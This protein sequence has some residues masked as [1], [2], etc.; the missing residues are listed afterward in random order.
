[1]NRQYVNPVPQ[2]DYS[3]RFTLD[4]KTEYV[5]FF[6]RN[7]GYQ[8]GV[9]NSFTLD[10]VEIGYQGYALTLKESKDYWPFGLELQQSEATAI[11]RGREYTYRQ[12]QG[13][14]HT[15]ELGLNIHEWR[16]RVSDPTIGR[17]WQVDPLAEE[18]MDWAPYVFSGN[19]LIDARELE[20]L[21]PVSIHSRSFIPFRTLGMFGEGG[22]FSGDN[23]GFGD[24]GRSRISGRTD[25]NLSGSGIE[26]L[27][28]KATGADTFDSDGNFIVHSDA[29][30]EL[31]EFGEQ[32]FADGTVAATNLRFHVSGNNDAIDGSPD[33]D[34]KGAFGIGVV[35]NKDG[36]SIATISGRISGDK[37]PVSETFITDQNGTRIFLGVSGA[38]GTPFT[39][40]PGNNNRTMSSFSI[41]VKFDTNGNAT[42]VNYN[43]TSFSIEDWNKRFTNLN[44]ASNISTND[45]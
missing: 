5:D 32:N 7:N 19:R 3:T 13:Q 15:K 39:S 38:D 30:F 23:R 37:F 10:N 11:T 42:G 4:P 16:Y 18:Y 14:E 41:N 35:D 27:G 29:N 20:G 22:S 45:N 12:F 17:F 34:L 43:G 1:M 26:L 33:I 40:L 36:S 8:D 28:R 9:E 24:P 2:G 31:F 25:L 6:I 44:A 21:E